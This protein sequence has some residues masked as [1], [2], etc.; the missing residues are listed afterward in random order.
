M[1]MKS[2]NLGFLLFLALSTRPAF[3]EFSAGLQR[4]V[5]SFIHGVMVASF[6]LF[7][8]VSVVWSVGL[9]ATRRIANPVTRWKTRTVIVV[10][11]LASLLSS[12]S[13]F[14]F[15]NLLGPR[16]ILLA[17]PLGFCMFPLSFFVLLRIS[18]AFAPQAASE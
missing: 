8:I 6:V 16:Q 15:A 3:A 2:R 9:L 17:F 1:V 10:F 5:Q 14:L 12:A 4:G 18:K 11:P 13:F 7:T